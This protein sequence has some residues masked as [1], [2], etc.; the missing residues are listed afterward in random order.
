QD[1]NAEEVIAQY[2]KG[3]KV[4]LVGHFPFVPRLKNRV[5]TL[6]VLELHPRPG[7]LPADAADEVIPQADVVAITSMTLL[8]RTFEH[9][10][11][12]P[13]PT[14]ITLLLGP[15]TP[16][17]PVLFNYG[18]NILSGSQVEDIPRVVRGVI[19]GA[20]FHQLHSLGVRLVSIQNGGIEIK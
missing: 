4:A 19:Q 12:L 10:I 16:L 6:W 1:I 11:T 2:G 13:K 17:S 7:D 3:K 5:G 18:V 20:N 8:N 15:T 14:A 9:L